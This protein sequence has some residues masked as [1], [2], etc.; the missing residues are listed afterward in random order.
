MRKHFVVSIVASGLVL[1]A[2]EGP[3]GPAGANGTNGNGG[4]PCYEGL[5][6]QNGDGTVDVLDC[7]G[8]DGT[9]G[10]NGT[11]GTNGTNGNNGS[12]GMDGIWQGNLSG[13][14]TNALSNAAMQDVAVDLDPMPASATMAHT[15]ASGMYGF[16][17]PIGVYMVTFSATGYP[18]VTEMVSIVANATVMLDVALSP[19][20]PFVVSI[21]APTATAPGG[22]ATLT[23]TA[24]A[25]NGASAP[26]YAWTQTAGPT[27]TIAN[28][29]TAA[30]GITLANVT[31]YKTALFTHLERHDRNMVMG[32]NPFALEE[33]GHTEFKVTV[34]A[35]GST[36]TKTVTM[37][38]TL[39]W[40]V[41]AGIRTIPRNIPVLLNAMDY[42][43]YDWAIASQ[44]SGTAD[45]L[46]DATTRNPYFVPTK[47]GVYDLTVSGATMHLYVDN[48]SD[49]IITGVGTDGR[50][51][52]STT[53][54]GCHDDSTAPD[55]FTPWAKSGHAEIFSSNIDNPAGH[56][57][58]A[59]ATCHGIGVDGNTANGGMDA[60]MATAN[61]TVPS[62]GEVG[63]Y[64]DMFADT[65]LA[66]IAK[67]ANIQC[68]NCH[69]PQ[70]TLVGHNKVG[71]D[72][73]ARTSLGSEV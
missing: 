32:I 37:P 50:P 5:T 64:E 13:T 71:T 28:G 44:P 57:G 69:G 40:A 36:Y 3:A 60:K 2:C 31:A 33:A 17:L 21:A 45:V 29:T 58:A 41:A 30:A 35:G 34:T 22:T 19:T 14:V 38:V 59:C 73:M 49:G 15:D 18:D 47:V 26:T 25:Y 12:N 11:N 23:A 6:D 56:W 9:N 51:T 42:G 46:V 1:M 53:C 4:A 65:N 68:E 62:H 48:Y 66:P 67:A 52:V 16:D 70:G 61:W 20:A 7:R 72:P 24:T 63:Y 54:T 27:A 39:P 10:N 8:Q 43:T 55:K